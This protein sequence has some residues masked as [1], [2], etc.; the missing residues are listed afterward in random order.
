MKQ[1]TMNVLIL[2]FFPGLLFCKKEMIISQDGDYIIEFILSIHDGDWKDDRKALSMN[3]VLAVEAI[4]SILGDIN[5]DQRLLPNIT[6]GYIIHDDYGSKRWTTELTMSLM[7]R[8]IQNTYRHGIRYQENSMFNH[9]RSPDPQGLLSKPVI[10]VVG[11]TTSDIGMRIATVL[12]PIEIPVISYMAT[13]NRLRKV[14]AFPFLVSL[15]PSDKY[16]AK[17]IMDLT[18][19]FQWSYILVVVSTSSYGIEGKL[20]GIW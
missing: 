18:D 9:S 20:S 3:N 5:N 8:I 14:N 15:L 12:R 4:I 19:E 16:Q 10:A 1:I 2:F 13:S 7:S 11:G 17:A 6:L